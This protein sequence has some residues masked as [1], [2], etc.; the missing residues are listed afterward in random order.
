MYDNPTRRGFQETN[1][2]EE[3]HRV[4]VRKAQ[5]KI[6]T[7]MRREELKYHYFNNCPEFY[8]ETLI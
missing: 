5:Y 2:P 3:N 6:C 7:K 4:E 8:L 1:K